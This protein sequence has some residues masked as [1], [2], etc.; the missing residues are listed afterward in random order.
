MECG[1]ASEELWFMWLPNMFT[2]RTCC[3]Q[4]LGTEEAAHLSSTVKEM[5][6]SFRRRTTQYNMPVIVPVYDLD[7]ISKSELQ[8][9]NSSLGWLQAY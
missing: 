1:N 2:V 3:W 6:V 8:L 7:K 9:D 5:M 4:M